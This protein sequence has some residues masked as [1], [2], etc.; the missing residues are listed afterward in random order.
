MVFNLIYFNCGCTTRDR[1]SCRSQLLPSLAGHKFGKLTTFCT[2]LSFSCNGSNS[3]RCNFI[4][5]PV[6][7]SWFLQKSTFPEFSA[8]QTE[9]WISVT[10]Q[11]QG[12]WCS[13]VSCGRLARSFVARKC[14]VARV[15][16]THAACVPHCA[17]KTTISDKV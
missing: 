6:M 2:F 4:R 13:R 8:C 5:V 1:G 3:S 10:K 11:T 12:N 15:P 14:A 16:R 9:L 17:N 7:C